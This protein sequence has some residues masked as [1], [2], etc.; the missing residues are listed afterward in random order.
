M[1]KHAFVILHFETIEVTNECVDSIIKNIGENQCEIVIVDNGSK[2]HSGIELKKKYDQ[3]EHVYVLLNKENKG[4]ARGNNIGYLFA[5]NVLKCDFVMLINSDTKVLQEEFLSIIEKKYE[6]TNFAVMGPLITK[7]GVPTSDN[8]RR[9]ELFV[10]KRIRAFIFLN[11]IQYILSFVRADA[12][13]DW[14]FRKYAD[15]KRKGIVEQVSTECQEDVGLHG[16]CLILS[17]TYSKYFKGLNEKT[18][19][20]LEEEILQYEVIT[21][22]LK[23][24]YSPEIRIEHAEAYTTSRVCKNTVEKR[25]FVYKNSIESAKVLLDLW[26]EA[27]DR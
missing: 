26:K 27:D 14:L 11:Q 21:A 2:N 22:G 10:P 12:G 17:P 25:R 9:E 18:F 24:L 7:E 8:P 16:C 5:K 6:E 19:M 13:I 3:K 4:F 1:Y 23:T 20:Y 15:A